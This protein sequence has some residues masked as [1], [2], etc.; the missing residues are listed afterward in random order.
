MNK[1]KVGGLSDVISVRKWTSEKF[2]SWVCLTTKDY[3]GRNDIDVYVHNLPVAV[4]EGDIIRVE[5]ILSVSA[6]YAVN[7]STGDWENKVSVNADISVVC[8]TENNK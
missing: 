4:E 2:G 3:K 5:R 6:G 1:I 8:K 7:G